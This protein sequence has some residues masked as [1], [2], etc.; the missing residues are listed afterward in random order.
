MIA[1]YD[2]NKDGKLDATER[3]AMQKEKFAKLDKNKDG[4][5]SFDEAQPLLKHRGGRG[6]GA[7]GRNHAGKKPR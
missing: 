2:A 5:L 4:V 7:E 3:L 1:K 6:R